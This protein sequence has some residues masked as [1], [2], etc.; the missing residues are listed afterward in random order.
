VALKRRRTSPE[1]ALRVSSDDPSSSSSSGP[2]FYYVPPPLVTAVEKDDV[3]L[4]CLARG[5]PP[6]S[7]PRV[8]WLRPGS[9][10]DENEVVAGRNGADNVVLRG[11]TPDDDGEYACELLSSRDGSVVVERHVTRLQV[12]Y[13]PRIAS[14]PQSVRAVLASRLRFNCTVDARPPATSVSWL[15]DG[16]RVVSP[17]T[18]VGRFR[19]KDD[20]QLVISNLATKDA[21]VYECVA[22][23]RVGSAVAAAKVTITTPATVVYEPINLQVTYP[24]RYTLFKILNN[25]LDNYGLSHNM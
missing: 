13:A 12:L 3:V 24:T 11:V 9:S 20:N 21:G 10:G 15:R 7:A 5:P 16:V 8:R 23:N 17:G 25:G 1:G 22:V 6:E 4:E 19:H 14:R 18:N 2:S